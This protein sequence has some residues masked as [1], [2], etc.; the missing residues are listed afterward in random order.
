MNQSILASIGDLRDDAES[1][2]I[3]ARL[4]IDERDPDKRAEWEAKYAATLRAARK[5]LMA[6]EGES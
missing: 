2:Q 4:V 1:L 3:L 6:I 5:R